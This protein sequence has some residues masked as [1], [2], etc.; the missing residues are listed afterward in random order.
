MSFKKLYDEINKGGVKWVDFHFFDAHCTLK[1]LTVNAD[2]NFDDYV[3][4]LAIN[5]GKEFLKP[6]RF[7]MAKIPWDPDTLRAVAQVFTGQEDEQSL[8][9]PTY[10]LTRAVMDLN[11]LGYD[12]SVS[13][14]TT[15]HTF[16]SSFISKN[17]FN[18]E[19]ANV[20]TSEQPQH[21]N[22]VWT[23]RD[24]QYAS[25]P[26]DV[27]NNFRKQIAEAMA[28][29]NYN[30]QRHHHAD[31]AF[32]KQR[33]T[34]VDL[35][36]EEAADAF[37][38]L[39]YVIK[40]VAAFN[41]LSVTFM[42][43]PFTTFTPNTAELRLTLT[44]GGVAAEDEMQYFAA[45]VMEH[46]HAITFL[47]FN[48]INSYKAFAK[49]NVQLKVG[50]DGLINLNK[51]RLYFRV[52]DSASCPYL[53]LATVISA[54]L[55][56]IKKKMSMPDKVQPLPKNLAEAIDAF[57]SDLSFIK[58]VVSPEFLE[59]YVEHMIN[60]NARVEKAVTHEERQLYFFV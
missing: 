16:E 13:T 58:H 28:A 8:L 15:F 32:G 17:V 57:E 1:H 25:Q 35:G 38:L 55:D 51:E 45:G 29:F 9:D 26:H 11:N 48:T 34:L 53:T 42:P 31:D 27:F 60:H 39:K 3:N 59:H 50:H 24:G 12:A 56:G 10:I 14:S 5:E 6:Q 41:T 18:E 23:D 30:V 52:M 7:G 33:I 19:S 36:V 54:G 43:L 4:V 40:N 21:G 47:T 46:L 2:E 49:R 44:K 22:S 20:Q 37:A